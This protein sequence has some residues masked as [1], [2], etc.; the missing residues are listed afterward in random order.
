LYIITLVLD[1]EDRDGVWYGGLWT[2]IDL[3]SCPRKCCQS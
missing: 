2:Q 1:T 3:A